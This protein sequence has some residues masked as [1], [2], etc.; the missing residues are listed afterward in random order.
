MP[1]NANFLGAAEFLVSKGFDVNARNSHGHTVIHVMAQRRT[2]TNDIPSAIFE[3]LS[4]CGADIDA[5]CGKDGVTALMLAAQSGNDVAVQTL[6]DAGANVN[7]TDHAMER[8]AAFYAIDEKGKESKSG[9]SNA[10]LVMLLKH[11]ANIDHRDKTGATPLHHLICTAKRD[12][13]AKILFKTLSQYGA[14]PTVRGPVEFPAQRAYHAPFYSA[15]KEYTKK[16][17]EDNVA[18]VSQVLE[19][20]IADEHEAVNIFTDTSEAYEQLK[21]A[22]VDAHESIDALV[23]E[24][25]FFRDTCLD[26]HAKCTTLRAEAKEMHMEIKELRKA[27]SMYSG[28]HSIEDSSDDDQDEPTG[29]QLYQRQCIEDEQDLYAESG[30]EQTIVYSSNNHARG[31]QHSRARRPSP[32]S[33]A[34][35]LRRHLARATPQACAAQLTEVTLFMLPYSY[36]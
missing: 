5:T 23:A 31:Y 15:L 16:Y 22:Y 20:P 26:Y 28:R 21:D 10:C 9:G 2:W 27:L 33:C 4:K 1:N 19:P 17:L 34:A 11:K 25:D 29:Y 18:D 14:D 8:T 12:D 6:I 35:S 32:G 7:A 36:L 3:Y 30:R 13:R 24:K